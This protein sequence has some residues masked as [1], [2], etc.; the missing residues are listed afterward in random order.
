M[1]LRAAVLKSDFQSFQLSNLNTA[2]TY[3][4]FPYLHYH[5]EF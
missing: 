4:L 1:P 2:F 5:F 3:L